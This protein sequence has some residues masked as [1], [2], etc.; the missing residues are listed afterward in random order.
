M[1]AFFGW[2]VTLA[3]VLVAVVGLHHYGYDLTGAVG[4]FLRS[5]EHFLGQPLLPS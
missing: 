3:L 2:T 4:S 1:G 5:V